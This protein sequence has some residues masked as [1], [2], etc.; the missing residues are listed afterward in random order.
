MKQ[1]FTYIATSP[2]GQL[3]KNTESDT[4]E[5]CLD[6]LMYINSTN[7]YPSWESLKSR[8][9]TIDEYEVEEHG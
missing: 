2:A 6:K 5:E 9:Y 7:R 3:L 4:F 8:G 1:Q